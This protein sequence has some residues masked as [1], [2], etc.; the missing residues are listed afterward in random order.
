MELPWDIWHLLLKLSGNVHSILLLS[1]FASFARHEL[2][3]GKK[4]N[5]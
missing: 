4:R 1:S 5:Q 3:A 2:M